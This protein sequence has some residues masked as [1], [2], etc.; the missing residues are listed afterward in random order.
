MGFLGNLY[1]RAKRKIGE[2]LSPVVSAVKV[3]TPQVVRNVPRVVQNVEQNVGRGLSGLYNRAQS[4]VRQ[5]P[6]PASYAV[7]KIKT[8]VVRPLQGYL[9]NPERVAKGVFTATTPFGAAN[10]LMS[11]KRSPVYKFFQPT[12]KLRLRDFAREIPDATWENVKTI[13]QWGTRFLIS[14]AE[15]PRAIKTGQATGKYYNTPFGKLGSFQTEA[16]ARVRR[17]D[18]LWKAMAYP[19]AKTLMG[20]GDVLMAA[21][22]ILSA[23][24]NLSKY[25]KIGEEVANVAKDLTSPR[26]RTAKLPAVRTIRYEKVPEVWAQ[27]GNQMR[28]LPVPIK[29]NVMVE[30]KVPVDFESKTFRSLSRPGLTIKAVRSKP[31]KFN[32]LEKNPYYLG[33]R[34]KYQVDIDNA[35]SELKKLIQ[36]ESDFIS[37]LQ[38]EFGGV[39]RIKTPDWQI[40][41][42]EGYRRASTNPLWYRKFY[43]EHGRAP[44][45]AEVAEIAKKELEAGRGMMGEEYQ[46]IK[47]FIEDAKKEM[48]PVFRGAIA[49]PERPLLLEAGRKPTVKEAK[50][51]F[52]K[53]GEAVEFENVLKPN[54]KPLLFG[55]HGGDFGN[56]KVRGGGPTEKVPISY[57]YEETLPVKN[58]STIRK[59]I[60]S[61]GTI[62]NKQGKAGQELAGRI[63]AQ[64]KTQDLLRGHYE[65][66]INEAYKGLSRREKYQV[67]QLLDGQ[68]VS[69]TERAVNTAQKMRDML[70]EAAKGAQERRLEIRVPGGNSVPFSPRENYYPRR[71]NFSELEK[72]AQREKALEHMVK[73][74]QARSRAEAQRM[75]DEFI[76]ANRERRA[77]NLENA[78]MY[79]L[80]GYEMDSKKALT[81]YFGS[82][83][84]R[85]SEVDYYG[86]KD[87]IAANLVR[88]IELAGGDPREAQRIFDYSIGNIPRNKAVSAVMQYNMATKLDMAFIA[89]ATQVINTAAKA[90]LWNTLKGAI[91]GSLPAGRRLA[92]RAGTLQKQGIFA[93]EAGL[94][95]NIV[96]AVLTPF[97]LV[98]NFNRRTAAYTG[99]ERAK[100][101]FTKA[102]QGDNYAI[103]ELERLGINPKSA[104]L[105]EN[106][107]LSA[108]W[109]MSRQTQFLVDPIDV[110]P[111][112]KT[113]LGKLLTQF[114]S[115]SFEQTKFVRDQV[116]KEA[117]MGNFAP[118]IRFVPLAIGASYAS[119]Y[120]RNL[121]TGR[122]P[123]DV[124]KNVD[125]RKWDQWMKA[126]GT[127]PTDLATQAKFLADTYGSDYLT[128]LQ[129]MGRV[130][131]TFGGPTIGSATSWL[132]AIE[133]INKTQEANKQ[134]GIEKKKA[135][136]YLYL[137]RQIA[138]DVPL[139]GEWA[140]NKFFSFP[141]STKTAEEKAEAAQWYDAKEK[142]F[143]NMTTREMNAFD[144]I[145]AYDPTDPQQRIT[146]YNLFRMY[147]AVFDAKKQLAIVSAN[148]DESKIDPLY[149]V[150]Q[151]VAEKY[152]AYESQNPGSLDAYNLKKAYPEITALGAA[153]GKYFERNP[154]DFQTDKVAGAMERPAPS[155]RAQALMDE[156]NFTDPEVR[157]YL[158][159]NNEYILNQRNL[160]Q[161]VGTSDSARSIGGEVYV[162]PELSK[163]LD[164]YFSF[165]KGSAERKQYALENPEIYEY[166]DKKYGSSGGGGRY[167]YGRGGSKKK[168]AKAK[169]SKVPGKVYVEHPRLE[170]ELRL[171]IRRSS[172]PSTS[173]TY[174]IKKAPKKQLKQ[175]KKYVIKL[176]SKTLT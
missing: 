106:D 86:R 162:S 125:V 122:D 173:K 36:G 135:D 77:G 52:R 22:P 90:G 176:G 2:W 42:Y 40:H 26:V 45:K 35:K 47:N 70:N 124:T 27:G 138:G 71:Y 34:P 93:K 24:Q 172:V 50:K 51:I 84:R 53:T 20:A 100:K 97:K 107:F 65:S 168:T 76:M 159:A 62:L 7:P 38:K 127:I 123:R 30:R 96:S 153:R 99:V 67:A 129:K 12:E 158:K 41:E 104:N 175:P 9:S 108:A 161:L 4:F 39:E 144:A 91:F 37:D 166:F 169:A 58:L 72:G 28:E 167:G 66:R 156:G 151:D 15:A 147:P 111:A 133:Q 80:P 163:K 21:K 136:P 130:I 149:L 142:L 43:K 155:D 98:E 152:I 92:V 117:R 120:V 60:T 18:P 23:A 75:L 101:L 113:P 81:D 88:K 44:S 171:A 25:G 137:K 69:A 1:N 6:T 10:K 119:Q 139:V 63:S 128:E 160:L 59:M 89:N 61:G 68:Q 145:P 49:E 54:E 16:Q 32:I 126:V 146:K 170:P 78:R 3:K 64:R 102:Q 29:R 164:V 94:M 154:I 143:A 73:S 14:A 131:G 121:L 74:G 48:T 150:P 33:E 148:G 82:V 118:L 55:T 115:F 5:Y 141:K 17:G 105:A 87:D 8:N 79:D 134:L 116:L 56:I 95:K 140:K 85:F 132:A 174:I 114:K 112:W 46:N 57:N 31:T 110:P 109:E 19:A 157:D 13:P 83:A 165:P 11:D 103:R